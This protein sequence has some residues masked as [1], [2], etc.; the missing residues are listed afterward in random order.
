MRNNL[1]KF[2]AVLLSAAIILSMFVAIPV[3]ASDMY[4]FDISEGAI[5]VEEGTNV[6]TINTLL[7]FMH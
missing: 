7:W 5:R 2:M 6:G 3:Y 1:K 4:T